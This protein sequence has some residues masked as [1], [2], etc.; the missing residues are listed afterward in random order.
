MIIYL[1]MSAVWAASVQATH[2]SG[3]FSIAGFSFGGKVPGSIYLGKN[4]EVDVQIMRPAGLPLISVTYTGQEVCFLFDFDNQYY[5]GT[6]EE[7]SE[8]SSGV[9]E[10]DQLHL[11]F[12]AQQEAIPQWTWHEK[13]NKL[14][15]V[16]IGNS[17]NMAQIRYNQWK[18]GEYN[19][20]NI[21]I[22]DTGWKLKGTIT[23]REET[24]WNFQ[25]SPPNEVEQLPLLKMRE[26]I[27]P[28]EQ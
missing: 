22:K 25:C 7:F 23:N 19:R 8:L 5:S 21:D 17:T 13:N 4:G 11:I 27:A 10:A 16:T 6:S 28:K 2:L 20:I 26:S 15:R 12:A 14:K 3:K 1:L 9:L 18:Q 24:Q